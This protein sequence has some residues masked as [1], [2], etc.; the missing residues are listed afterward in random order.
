[1]GR[2]AAA[3]SALT[4]KS[5][6]AGAM[7]ARVSP[8]SGYVPQ[9]GTYELLQAYKTNPWLHSLT[10][11][12]ATAVATQV[13]ELRRPSR[14]RR[15]LLE[16]RAVSP[17]DD[18]V[19][20]HPLLD[21][22][23]EPCPK[24]DGH[25]VWEVT[26][27]WLDLKGEAFWIKE[28]EATGE[29]VQLWPAAPHWC[30][31]TPTEKEPSFSF[32]FGGLSGGSQN[33]SVPQD[34]VVWFR[35]LDPLNPY[36]RGTGT[37]EAL[38]DELD[39][40][41]YASK[42]VKA[43]FY[44]GGVPDFIISAKSMTT[45]NA[46]A[47]KEVFDSHYRGFWN[48]FKAWWV[49]GEV[50]VERLD[51][52]F[53]D[54]N[55]VQLRQLARDICIQTFGVPPEAIGVIENSNRATIEAAFYLFALLVLL[56]RLMRF[57]LTL[58]AQLVRP[59]FGDDVELGF[60]SPVPE[61]KDYKLKV[62][63]A[64][65]AAFTDN[66]VRRLGGFPEVEGKDEFPA[67]KPVFG[68]S[69]DPGERG[70][71]E[72]VLPE[73]RLHRVRPARFSPRRL[74]RGISKADIERVVDAAVEE[75]DLSAAVEP[76]LR[77]ELVAWANAVLEE[78]EASPEKLDI[79][80]PLLA[81]YLKE[82]SATR[83]KGMVDETTRQTLRDSL[84]EG[85]EDG[86]SMSEMADRVSEVFD[87]AEGSRADT[88]ARTEVL[89]SANWATWQAQAV[90]DV[91]EQRQWVAT[92]DDRTRDSHRDMDGVTVG[93]EEPFELISG[94]NAGERAMF[95][96]GFTAGAESINC[97][98]TSYAVLE[99][100]E[101]MARAADLRAVWKRFDRELRPVESKVTRALRRGFAAQRRAALRA[102]EGR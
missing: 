67:P 58:M 99:G 9:R 48:S 65:P 38:A 77:G 91:V 94:E 41:E 35:E 57:K 19:T 54:M 36:G 95:P 11:K 92:M 102:L 89:R 32:S 63:Q 27:V 43:F 81:K 21:L 44:N 73:S 17:G 52:S 6:G 47:A 8:S 97:R 66:E 86:E 37:G 101:S 87:E 85:L 29:V 18:L 61:D 10:N 3:W 33:W 69:L 46:R 75:A 42:R 71:A 2:F 90:S 56:P 13:W 78:L 68:L 45:E 96:G 1:M 12:I 25:Q 83:I 50:A 23:K 20:D 74:T 39:T 80:A 4:G 34:D 72:L 53:K 24:M 88:I 98:C 16:G 31:R 60:V 79:F 30:V 59:D 14:V 93:I 40:D 26:Q 100:E 22:L 49:P 64:R 7:A 70:W 5:A 15:G 62:T 76:A 55:L 51:T 84:L 82:M 28:R